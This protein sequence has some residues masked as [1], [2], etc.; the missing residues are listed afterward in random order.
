MSFEPDD[1]N[2]CAETVATSDPTRFRAVMAAP[3][4]AR[5]PLLALY[6]MNV[7]VARAPW[8]SQEALVT[9]MRLQWWADAMNAISDRTVVPRHPAVTSL[10][11][12]LNPHQAGLLS[13]LVEARR[14][15]IYR[16]PF[17]DNAAFD[18]YID[19]TSGNLMVVAATLLGAADE[20]VVRDYAYAV[21][22]ANFVMALPDLRA[23]GWQLDLDQ[24]DILTRAQTRLARAR[25]N[26]GGVSKQAAPAMF[27]GWRTARTIAQLRRGN[28]Y[29]TPF[30]DAL[31]LMW[32]ALSGRW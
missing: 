6:A 15:D 22:A 21:G 29:D 10:A 5:P 23:L 13:D 16:E 1:I 7:E 2:A 11:H 8:A 31:G 28:V 32:T 18:A 25:R 12:M 27:V 14:A 17:A 24:G 19:A 26:R 9:E 3:V 4:A 30:R 20:Q